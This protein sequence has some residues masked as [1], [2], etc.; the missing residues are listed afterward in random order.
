[1]CDEQPPP[2]H[3]PALPPCPSPPSPSPPCPPSFRI[4]NAELLT[5]LRKLA[6]DKDLQSKWRAV[7]LQRKAKLATVVKKLTGDDIPINAMFDIQVSSLTVFV[8]W[9]DG[10]GAL[11]RS[12]ISSGGS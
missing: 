6:S 8:L 11:I 4:N 12:L 9:F 10:G 7:K 5:G 1:M 2:C 3:S